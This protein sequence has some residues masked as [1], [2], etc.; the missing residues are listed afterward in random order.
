MPVTLAGATRCPSSSTSVRIVPKPRK[1][2]ALKPL[3]PVL[4]AL[5][6]TSGPVLPCSAGSS[7]TVSKTLDCA[8]F[9]IISA[10][11]TVMGVG[12]LNP[13]LVIRVEDTITCSERDAS[14]GAA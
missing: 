7:V 14:T 8:L 6:L 1:P 13:I 9:A 5:V 4:V 10:L 3:R 11:T 2:K 12:A